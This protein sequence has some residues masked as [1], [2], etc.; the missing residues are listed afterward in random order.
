[1]K[2]DLH[3]HSN[4]SRDGTASPSEIVEF[5]KESGMDGFAIADHNAIE[6]SLQA[7]EIGRSMGLV[8]VRGVEVSAEEGHVLAYGVTELV[9]RGLSI[10]D[11][12]AKIHALGGIAV[13]AHPDRFPSG[14][15]VDLAGKERFDAIE[16][17]NGAS[18]KRSNRLA[19][20]VADERR[21]PV[22]GGS[23]AHVID[24]IGKAYT[25]LE[26]VSSEDQVLDMIRKGLCAVGGRSRSSTEGLV[27]SIETLI[28]WLRG[29]LKR[30]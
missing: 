11:T 26:D 17:L 1:M 23:D 4:H 24:D 8:V 3:I 13:A 20:R 19:R 27:F 2:L 6:G 25:I 30:L 7:Y 18:S 15:G 14:M 28:E 5:C 9:P 16:V 10:A 22:T 29:G 12:I 21:A